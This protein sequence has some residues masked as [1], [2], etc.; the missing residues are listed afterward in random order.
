MTHSTRKKPA[1][2][3]TGGAGLIGSNLVRRLV[4]YGHRVIVVDDLSRGRLEHLTDNGT[5]IIDT[6]HDFY[7]LDLTL[8]HALQ[9]LL[10]NQEVD[11][12]YH[13]ADVVGGIDYVFNNEGYVFRQNIM[14]NSNVIETLKKQADAIQ[15]FI[16][17]GTACSFPADKQTSSYNK[18]L[19][20][21]DQYPAAP[22][23]AYG[24]SKLMGEY[25]AFL[26]EK[27]YHI[28]VSILT[29]HNVYGPPSDYSRERSQVIPALIRKAINYPEEDYV[30][31]GSG[32]Q[33]RAFVHVDD[34]VDALVAAMS[35]AL[36]KGLIQ[37]GPDQCTSIRK[38]AEIIAQISGKGIKIH[39]DSC[40]PEGD[41]WRYADC[42]KARQILGWSS[43]T[44]LQDGLARLYEWIENDMASSASQE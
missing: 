8:P 42:T 39:Y 16:Y 19:K 3:V 21:T 34:V 27:E 12:I 40:R 15:G 22:E 4:S 43:T 1:I 24:W 25:E 11:Y 17:V 23:S 36:G 28:P 33:G 32:K 6:S 29:L 38:V 26:L 31:W 7:K 18:P 10:A 30:V 35:K 2:L 5:A 14:I 9:P 44:D 20:E 13:L 37:I 41:E